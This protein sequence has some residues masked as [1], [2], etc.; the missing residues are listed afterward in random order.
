M[1]LKSTSN[2]Q[3]KSVIPANWGSE[4]AMQGIFFEEDLNF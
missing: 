3:K 4:V 2:V 1:V